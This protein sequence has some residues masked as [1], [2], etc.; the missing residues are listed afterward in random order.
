MQEAILNTIRELAQVLDSVRQ[1]GLGKIINLLLLPLDAMHA[2]F[3][4][5]HFVL[6]AQLV[7]FWIVPF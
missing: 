7:V 4:G 6:K 1:E 2:M 5:K 3:Q